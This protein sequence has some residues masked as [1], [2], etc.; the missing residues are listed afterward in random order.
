MYSSSWRPDRLPAAG[1]DGPFTPYG[2]THDAAA[3]IAATVR[4]TW[5]AGDASAPSLREDLFGLKTDALNR[6]RDALHP[7]KTHA[8]GYL[9][10]LRLASDLCG[11]EDA[12]ALARAAATAG[13]DAVTALA[14]E[15]E[16][17]FLAPAQSPFRGARE[18]AAFFWRQEAVEETNGSG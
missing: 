17:A 1:E 13:A 9:V 14:L 7:Q 18:A 8:F 10:S 3:A 5:G 6:L 11:C 4:I 2:L 15:R 16:A 12:I